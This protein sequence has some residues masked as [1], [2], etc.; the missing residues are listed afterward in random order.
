MLPRFPSRIRLALLPTPFRS[1]DRVSEELGGPRIW[2]KCDDMTGALLSGNKVRKLEY[3]IAEAVEN[4][5]DTLIT[6]GGLQ[7][8]HCRATALAGAQLG[9]KVHLILRGDPEIQEWDG[10]LL[11]DQ[12]AGAKVSIYSPKEYF[13]RLPELFRFWESHYVAEGRKVHLIPTGASDATGLWGYIA[14]SYELATDFETHHLTP[15]LVVCATGSGG[16]QAGLSLGFA[17]QNHPVKILG[18]AVCDSEKYFFD[19][20]RSDIRDWERRF[21]GYVPDLASVKQ[22]L[23]INT[24]DKYIGSGYA[25]AYPEVYQTIR[26]LAE[27][28]G[29]VLDPVYTGKA[30][31]GLVEEI[32][33]GAFR[34]MKDIVF[35]HTGG[36]YGLFPYRQ[37]FFSRSNKLNK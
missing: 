26:W 6:C 14:A 1:L 3:V 30:F 33:A 5:A 29:V 12:L 32:R 11:L 4:D 25:V 22:H 19:K 16:T 21:T 36:I 23:A 17:L 35:I 24:N 27:K 13:A 9:L 15:G 20:A 7:S 18:M 34:E 10:N 2:L 28:E 31:H 37:D 8:N